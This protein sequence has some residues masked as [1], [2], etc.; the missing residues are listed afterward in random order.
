MLAGAEE[1]ARYETQLSLF[2]TWLGFLTRINAL[3]SMAGFAVQYWFYAQLD[4]L[5]REGRA[6]PGMSVIT[7]TRRVAGLQKQL[8]AARQSP[9]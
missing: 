1:L 8:L 2:P 7:A 6:D 3:R 5:G 9:A 4:A